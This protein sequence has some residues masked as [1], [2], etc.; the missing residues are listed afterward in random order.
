MLDIQNK[1]K[2]IKLYKNVLLTNEHHQ[3]TYLVKKYMEIEF[4]N[5]NII[6][7]NLDANSDI[8]NCDYLVIADKGKLVKTIFKNA[9]VR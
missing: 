2:I 3:A 1:V 9:L 4:F 5:N 7:I 8:T 6:R